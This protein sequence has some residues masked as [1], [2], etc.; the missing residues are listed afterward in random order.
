[1]DLAELPQNPV[2]TPWGQRHSTN[3]HVKCGF[4]WNLDPGHFIRQCQHHKTHLFISGEGYSKALSG[5]SVSAY[6]RLG[7]QIALVNDLSHLWSLLDTTVEI[8]AQWADEVS[9]AGS[10]GSE[11]M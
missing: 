1:M 9:S 6:W 3:L 4:L 5:V 2:G 7:T 10:L 8:S 11:S